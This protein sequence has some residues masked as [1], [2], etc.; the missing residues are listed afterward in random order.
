[1]R[2]RL[3]GETA[4]ADLNPLLSESVNLG[5]GGQ[6]VKKIHAGDSQNGIVSRLCPALELAEVILGERCTYNVSTIRA[7]TTTQYTLVNVIKARLEH[8]GFHLVP[9]E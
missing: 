8:K 5:R 2:L 4:C 7:L 1:M 3:A 9:D 6:Q